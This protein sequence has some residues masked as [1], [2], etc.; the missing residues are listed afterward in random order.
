V[1]V[2]GFGRSVSQKTVWVNKEALQNVWDGGI[3]KMSDYGT[4]LHPISDETIK[5]LPENLFR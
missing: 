5:N 3:I 2:N 4:A 1:Q